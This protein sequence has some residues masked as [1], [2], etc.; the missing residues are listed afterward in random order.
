MNKSCMNVSL[1]TP[2]G[3]IVGKEKMRE[4]RNSVS[5]KKS[6]KIKNNA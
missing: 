2:I 3:V 1:S 6:R 5:P 4:I